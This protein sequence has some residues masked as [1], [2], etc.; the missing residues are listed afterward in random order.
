VPDNF[1]AVGAVG[2][3]IRA[4]GAGSACAGRRT[5]IDR[6]RRACDRIVGEIDGGRVD[7]RQCWAHYQVQSV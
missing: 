7:L 3:M 1:S 5:G 2:A 4:I 6:I